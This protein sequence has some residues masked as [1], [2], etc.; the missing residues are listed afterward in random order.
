MLQ[1]GSRGSADRDQEIDPSSR[2]GRAGP[3]SARPALNPGLSLPARGKRVLRSPPEGNAHPMRL[4]TEN[5][6][7][8]LSAA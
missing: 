4:S 1:S 5:R 8:T 2:S 3:A 6:R 7:Q